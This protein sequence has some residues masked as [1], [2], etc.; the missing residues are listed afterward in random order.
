MNEDAMHFRLLKVPTPGCNL[1]VAV[2]GEGPPVMLIHGALATHHEWSPLAM[3]LME[4]F[5]VI[6]PDV[7]GHGRSLCRDRGMMHWDQLCDDVIAILDHLGIDKSAIGGGSLGSAISA[8]TALRFP[9]RLS[10]VMLMTPAHTDAKDAFAPFATAAQASSVALV[11]DLAERLASTGF[12]AVVQYVT[13]QIA[14]DDLSKAFL[15]IDLLTMHDPESIAALF[16]SVL[17]GRR[18]PWNSLE[19]LRGITQ[20]VLVVPGDDPSHPREVAER[21]MTVLTAATLTKASWNA[22]VDRNAEIS[23]FLDRL[24]LDEE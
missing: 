12:D 18:A 23:R 21:Y 5:T 13:R 17:S 20:P 19:E 1:H 7:R 10:A 2:Y 22:A 14:A 8:G 3:S 11:A 6:T 4:R 24:Y 16:A 15:R 9:D